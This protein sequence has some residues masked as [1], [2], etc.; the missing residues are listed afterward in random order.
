[1]VVATISLLTSPYENQ[2]LYEHHKSRMNTHSSRSYVLHLRLSGITL[3]K[4]NT[5]ILIL[6]LYTVLSMHRSPIYEV[7]SALVSTVWA[8][9]FNQARLIYIHTHLL[10]SRPQTEVRRDFCFI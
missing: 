3:T 8:L 2:L 6:P 7:D 5:F 10:Q 9:Q 4:P 1:M